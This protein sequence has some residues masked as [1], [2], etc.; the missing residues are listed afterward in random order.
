VR[1]A[2]DFQ[3]RGREERA[4]HSGA[5]SHQS[6]ELGGSRGGGDAAAPGRAVCV[7]AHISGHCVAAD[8]CGISTGERAGG[9]ET[10]RDEGGR[11][12]SNAGVDG[13]ARHDGADAFLRRTEPSALMYRWH[14]WWVPTPLQQGH[15][16]Q[17]QP[18]RTQW[19]FLVEGHRRINTVT[20]Q[21]VA[22]GC[23]W[24]TLCA[25]ALS[26]RR[27]HGVHTCVLANGSASF[28]SHAIHID[29]IRHFYSNWADPNTKD[30][31]AN[32]GPS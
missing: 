26:R 1:R 30:S 29:Q 8:R 28:Q 17:P 5:S 20:D 32:S 7:A 12:P 15:Q 24:K 14:F 16:T 27:V 18:S 23:W 22:S 6:S 3:S 10:V 9:G 11:E 25:K 13:G 21:C 4:G 2:S 31:Q 19:C